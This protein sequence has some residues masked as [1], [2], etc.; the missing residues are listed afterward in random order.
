MDQTRKKPGETLKMALIPPQVR[1]L[2]SNNQETK[3]ISKQLHFL[4]LINRKGKINHHR[5]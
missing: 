3:T 1:S 4:P 5:L 2:V